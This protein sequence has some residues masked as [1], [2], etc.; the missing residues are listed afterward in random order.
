MANKPEDTKSEAP[1]KVEN[2]GPRKGKNNEYLPAK[3]PGR[4]GNIREDR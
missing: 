3:Y 1:K 4:N 2:A